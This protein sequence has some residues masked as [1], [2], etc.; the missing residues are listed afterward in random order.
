M[1]PKLKIDSYYGLKHEK[2]ER[3][4]NAVFCSEFC[5]YGEYQ[6]VLVFKAKNPDVSKGHKKYIF[7]NY[8]P[9]SEVLIIRGMT[10]YEMKKWRYQDAAICLNCNSLIYSIMRHHEQSCECGSISID[11]GKDYTKISYTKLGDLLQVRIDLITGKVR[12]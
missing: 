11:G 5:V 3:K 9:E 6:P 12:K 4:Y 7:F 8:L 2:I 10:P 1:K